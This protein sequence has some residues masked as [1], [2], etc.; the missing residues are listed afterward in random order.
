VPTVSALALAH[1][2][3]VQSELRTLSMQRGLRFIA[4]AVLV[5][6]GLTAVGEEQPG[7]DLS[8]VVFGVTLLFLAIGELASMAQTGLRLRQRNDLEKAHPELAVKGKPA[9]WAH[10]LGFVSGP[11]F[12]AALYALLGAAFLVGAS[13]PGV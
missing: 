2:E 12:S 3:D 5:P 11:G 10:A 4:V 1:W 13:L 8:S 6:F 9:R 7:P